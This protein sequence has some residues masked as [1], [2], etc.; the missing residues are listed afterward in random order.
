MQAKNSMRIAFL[1]STTQSYYDQTVT[2]II[3][4]VQAS[5]VPSSD[6]FIVS[7]QEDSDESLLHNNVKIFKVTYTAIHLT[8]LIH[9]LENFNIYEKYTHFC[10]L[11]STSNIGATFYKKLKNILSK[12]RAPI[13]ALP[14]SSQ[15]TNT[16]DMG[17]VSRDQIASLQNYFK[18]I[19]LEEYNPDSL[20]QLKKQLI[21]DENL[22][23][24][25]KP[26]VPHLSTDFKLI[27]CGRQLVYIDG[28]ENNS[29]LII[30]TIKLGD[31]TLRRTFY[32]SLDFYKYQR[33]FQGLHNIS[34]NSN[35]SIPT[36]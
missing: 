30:D 14:F 15:S 33:T 1:I 13:D 19:K 8:P 24:G 20:L 28:I 17:I 34:M 22:I 2:R 32:P 7:S 35:G 16:K 25:L 18:T 12:L 31:E 26:S 4:E 36:N 10:L 11:H 9:V 23:F 21:F 6:L 29:S 5:G 27:N 3:S